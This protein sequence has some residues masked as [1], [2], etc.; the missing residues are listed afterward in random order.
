[1]TC[2]FLEDLAVSRAKSNPRGKQSEISENCKNAVQTVRDEV[3]FV[4]DLAGVV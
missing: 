3:G 2:T 1:M 4:R